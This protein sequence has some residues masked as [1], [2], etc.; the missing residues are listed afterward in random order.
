MERD[1]SH[2]SPGTKLDAITRRSQG[3]APVGDVDRPQ[4]SLRASK[5]AEA[6]EVTGR[7]PVIGPGRDDL[8][9]RPPSPPQLVVGGNELSSMDAE[10]C[11]RQGEGLSW[12]AP[13]V[14]GEPGDTHLPLVDGVVRRQVIV[15][16]GPV[17]SDAVETADTKIGGIE[18]PEVAGITDGAAAD[19]VIEK[20]T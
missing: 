9:G 14:S 10:R 12:R 16:D 13:G 8:L 11:R 20:D 2:T 4:C 18:A 15:A 3:F 6:L 17:D 19:G 1:L 5:W 7:A